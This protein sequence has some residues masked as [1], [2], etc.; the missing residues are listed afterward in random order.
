M[1]ARCLQ[2]MS[3][4]SPH[5]GDLLDQFPSACCVSPHNVEAG[6]IEVLAHLVAVTLQSRALD[7]HMNQPMRASP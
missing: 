1:H 6:P 5:D 7:G 3:N 2:A 4:A